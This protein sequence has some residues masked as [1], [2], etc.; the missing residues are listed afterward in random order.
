M[1]I[2]RVAPAGWPTSTAEGNTPKFITNTSANAMAAPGAISGHMTRR[3]TTHGLAP[4][5]RAEASRAGSMPEM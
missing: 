4:S 1:A 3:K 5:T 2:V